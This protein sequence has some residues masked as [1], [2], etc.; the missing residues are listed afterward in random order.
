MGRRPS[1]AVDSDV[2]KESASPYLAE[3]MKSLAVKFYPR[4]LYLLERLAVH[5]AIPDLNRSATLRRCLEEYAHDPSPPL[6]W[7]QARPRK[8]R[9]A[10]RTAN[11]VRPRRVDDPDTPDISQEN[12]SP[13]LTIAQIAQL[14][15][16]ADRFR[17]NRTAV[18]YQAI[19]DAAARAGIQDPSDPVDLRAPSSWDPIIPKRRPGQ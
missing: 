4:F 9:M 10:A 6:N 8:P 18:M 1:R 12:F 2:L 15:A 7:A 19:W 14:T 17:S 5:W 16:W 13:V 11:P 3:Q